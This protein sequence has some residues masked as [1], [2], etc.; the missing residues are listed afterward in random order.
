MK[1]KG[2]LRQINEN[3]EYDP[4]QGW[5]VSNKFLYTDDAWKTTKSVFGKYT[6]DGQERWGILSDA[7]I[8]GFV[9]GSQIEG[10]EIRIGKIPGTEDYTFVVTNDGMVQINAWGGEMANRIEEIEDSIN[11]YTVSIESSTLPVFDENIRSTVL[12]CTVFQNGQEVKTENLPL[13]TAYTWIRSSNNEADD[14]TWN[15]LH[16]NIVGTNWITIDADEDVYS[17]ARFI[18]EVNIPQEENV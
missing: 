3:G 18:C 15:N 14:K 5:I 13:A 1:H 11:A 4:E 10:G 8:G 9:Q 2:H 17:S 12:T 7:L 16:K 6:Y